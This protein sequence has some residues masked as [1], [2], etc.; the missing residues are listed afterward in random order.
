M[1]SASELDLYL[2]SREIREHLVGEVL[3]T[4]RRTR[5]QGLWLETRTGKGCWISLDPAHLMAVVA[6]SCP[7]T[8]EDPHPFLDRFL[9]KRRLRRVHVPPGERLLMLHFGDRGLVVELIGGQR[10]V[11][12][13]DADTR[14]RHSLFSSRLPL[15]QPYTPPPHVPG[16]RDWL[17]GDAPPPSWLDRVAP[18]LVRVERPRAYVERVLKTPE[19]VLVISPEGLPFPAPGPIPLDPGEEMHHRATLSE[20]FLEVWRHHVSPSPNVLATPVRDPHARMRAELERLERRIP[21]LQKLAERLMAH[22][23]P[24]TPLRLQE[25]GEEVELRPGEDPRAVASDLYAE[26]HRLR[27]G[28]ETLRQ[29]LKTSAP[30]AVPANPSV[31][32][33]APSPR[34]SRSYRL[35]RAPSGARVLAGTSAVSN[36]H[37]TFHLARPRDWFFHIKDHPG[38]HV[39]LRVT[40]DSPPEED[41]RFA[42]QLALWLAR[43]HPGDVAEVWMTPRRYVRSLPGQPGKVRFQKVQTLRVVLPE[44]FQP[45]EL[46]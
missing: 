28:M 3:R 6:P 42:A 36:H 31:R 18:Y 4:V 22:P 5:P 46:P 40:G 15:G 33:D 8:P 37:V 1:P 38:P 16:L 25:N 17:R 29:R 13:L 27:R 26:I 9:H 2:L 21:A 20:A 11:Y 14:V 7:A 41:Q 24:Q 10:N 32:R 35:Y 23:V 30:P 43:L 44:D 45:E 39:L 19:P 34:P 12:A